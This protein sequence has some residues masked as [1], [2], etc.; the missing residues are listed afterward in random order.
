MTSKLPSPWS[1]SLQQQTRTAIEQLPVT[2]DGNL[3]F[4]H[5]TLGFS[6]A[7]LDDL[8]HDTLLLQEKNGHNTFT[9]ASVDA[10]LWAGW[11]LD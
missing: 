5:A 1:E 8:M 4:K 7:T 6:Y 3:H 11:V 9:F 10:L 2:A